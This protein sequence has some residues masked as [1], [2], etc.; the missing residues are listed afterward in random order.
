MGINLKDPQERCGTRQ[1]IILLHQGC[2]CV[3]PA[4]FPL[5]VYACRAFYIDVKIIIWPLTI[6][7]R[8]RNTY[9]STRRRIRNA[10]TSS[11][12]PWQLVSSRFWF[13]GKVSRRGKRNQSTVRICVKKTNNLK[14]DD[15]SAPRAAVH[16][17]S[18]SG[19]Q[20]RHDKDVNLVHTWLVDGFISRQLWHEQTEN[21]ALRPDKGKMFAFG[22][23]GSD[24]WWKCHRQLLMPSFVFN[25]F[26]LSFKELLGN[27][28]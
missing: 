19:W 18:T 22:S 1:G 12:L 2:T 10:M 13:S 16:Y 15:W 17:P 6:E 8:L 7:R 27:K 20:R 9:W 24:R 4:G 23:P 25:R 11:G 5:Q 14:I 28:N 21:E 3:H 26:H